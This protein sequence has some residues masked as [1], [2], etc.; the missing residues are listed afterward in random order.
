MDLNNR[1]IVWAPEMSAGNERKQLII[2]HSLQTM[3]AFNSGL[4]HV[5]V[6]LLFLLSFHCFHRCIFFFFFWVLELPFFPHSPL[7]H[8]STTKMQDRAECEGAL[9]FHMQRIN[10]GTARKA[11]TGANSGCPNLFYHSST[12][13]LPT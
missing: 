1:A 10:T 6:P 3:M 5:F 12:A 13:P 4:Y 7:S 9:E 8:C 11:Y 2:H